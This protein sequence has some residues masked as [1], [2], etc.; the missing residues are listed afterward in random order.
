MIISNF[1]ANFY[2]AQT[3]HLRKGYKIPTN[4]NQVTNS[5]FVFSASLGVSINLKNTS[6]KSLGKIVNYFSTIDLNFY[7]F[8]SFITHVG[9]DVC[10]EMHAVTKI[11]EICQI[12]KFASTNLT[13]IRQNRKF[14][15]TD[16]ALT[17]FTKIR[18]HR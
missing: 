14:R 7:R 6:M 2:H 8:T 17:N 18:L 15:Q 16:F 13:E 12:V 4:L 3:S 1:P 5:S 11:G 9:K 10:P